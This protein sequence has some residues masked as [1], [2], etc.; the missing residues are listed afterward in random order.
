ML[1]VKHL[2]PNVIT[3]FYAITFAVRLARPLKLGSL[4]PFYTMNS[5]FDQ[6]ALHQL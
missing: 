2:K 1:Q 4:P 5:C 6:A 3:G